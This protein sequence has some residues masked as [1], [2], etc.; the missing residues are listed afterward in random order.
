VCQSL[1]ILSW[2]ITAGLLRMFGCNLK[3]G[4]CSF[5][6]SYFPV[7]EHKEHKGQVTPYVCVYSFIVQVMAWIDQ[8][9]VTAN[10]GYVALRQGCA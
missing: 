1:S 6:V 5:I 2:S 8:D 3:A 9:R 10:V 7:L 4:L